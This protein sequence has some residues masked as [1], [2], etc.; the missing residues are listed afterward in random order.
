VPDAFEHRSEHLSSLKSEESF[1][2]IDEYY[3]QV[4]HWFK[5]AFI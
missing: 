5:G 3:L 1:D 2:W 4:V